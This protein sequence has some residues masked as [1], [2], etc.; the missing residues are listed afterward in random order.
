MLVV[1]FSALLHVSWNVLVRNSTDKFSST[2][3]VVLGAGLLAVPLLVWLPLPSVPSYPYIL[4][5]GL[6]HVVYFSLVAASYRGAELSLAYPLMRGAAPA[7]AALTALL[8]LGESPATMGWLGITFICGGVLSLAWG[9]W[10][11]SPTHA[12]AVVLALVNA[13]IVASYTVIDGHGA[14]LSDHAPA[15]TGWTFVLT[16]LL[17]AAAQGVKRGPSALA[18]VGPIWRT[19][20]V[21]GA[22]TLLAYGMVLWAMTHA[23]I[24]VVAALRESSIVFA[25]L[26]GVVFLKERISRLRWLAIGLVCAGAVCIKIS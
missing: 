3:A 8:W 5:S 16:A 25:A 23:P 6:I 17:M 14:R 12:G 1:L 9:A 19:A 24:A 26:I 20:L 7:L 2:L 15:Y 21:G 22:C 11:T 18:A 13:G 10:K 4:A